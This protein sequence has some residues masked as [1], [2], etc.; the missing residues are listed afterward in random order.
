MERAE[1]AGKRIALG[2]TGGIA[3]YKAAELVRLLAKAGTSVQVAMSE[4]ATHFVAPLTFQA[5]SGH[6]VLTD[7]QSSSSDSG[8]AH[9]RFSRESNL[10]L[11]APA[12]ANYLA[13]TAHG[14]ADNL[15]T[16]LTL[17][18]NC[19]LLVA[20]AMNREMWGKSATQRKRQAGQHLCRYR[21]PP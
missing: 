15:L 21:A 3:A 5:L 10:L 8:M 12:T 14:L 11:I 9:I 13:K 20:P 18:R 16:T 17:A 6:P 1:L 4:A 7:Q 19:P 2:I